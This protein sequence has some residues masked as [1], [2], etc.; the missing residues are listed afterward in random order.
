MT[1]FTLLVVPDGRAVL[2]TTE[3]LSDAD[4]AEVR[5]QVKGW[6]DGEWPVLVI[7]DA[8]VVQVAAIDLDLT[9]A[10]GGALS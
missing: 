5:R 3:D 4:V 2:T 10:A 9:P 1:R 8:E 7:P 6:K